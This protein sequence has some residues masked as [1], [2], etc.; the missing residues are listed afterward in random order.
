MPHCILEYSDNIIENPNSHEILGIINKKLAETKLFSLNDIK[1]RILVHHDFVVG[2]GDSDRAFVTINLSILSGRNDEIK[3]K[4]SDT[5]LNC[6]EEYFS[7]SLNKLKLSL[8]VQISE[9]DKNTYG[10]L[11]NY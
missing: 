2:D 5:L 9:L 1:S 10:R 6:L 11:K 7:E 3:K 8:T 4:L